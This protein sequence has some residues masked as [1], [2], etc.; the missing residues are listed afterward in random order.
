MTVPMHHLLAG[1]A[2]AGLLFLLPVRD[3]N[4]QDNRN[5]WD[6]GTA[7][8]VL[9]FIA[10]GA[11]GGILGWRLSKLASKAK[12][13]DNTTE[14]AL[15]Q[16]NSSVKV[17]DG[18][19][20]KLETNS[21]ESIQGLSHILESKMNP[22]SVMSTVS[23]S[24]ETVKQHI[25]EVK[26][27]IERAIEK[28]E[29]NQTGPCT[30][31]PDQTIEIH[32]NQSRSIIIDANAAID[33]RIF[34]LLEY[35]LLEEL[36]GQ[37]IIA[38]CMT[39][40]L[41]RLEP[42]LRANGFDNLWSFQGKDKNRIDY[43]NNY[44][45]KI[46]DARLLQLTSG[47]DDDKELFQG[48]SNA[49]KKL[50]LLTSDTNGILITADR[51]LVECCRNRNVRVLNLDEL[52]KI[53]NKPPEIKPP[54]LKKGD[55]VDVELEKSNKNP[56]DAINRSCGPIIVVKDAVEFIGQTKRVV[57][58]GALKNGRAYFASLLPSPNA[59]PPTV[60]AKAPQTP[61]AP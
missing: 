21:E 56:N 29:N 33:G 47:T 18:K 39:N 59:E 13:D 37:I 24:L 49:D 22:G 20:T 5:T 4:A 52:N 50:F 23:T 48:I 26:E 42:E 60:E 28:K 14:L 16:L 43:N 51:K 12:R 27:M 32:N 35:D 2:V 61:P 57:I 36:R 25:I 44:E 58:T 54:I 3:A 46:T 30:S 1:S 38:E 41:K 7:G 53:T 17:L 9:T 11:V 10:G 31:N 45:S 19:L 40:E 34:T 8:G 55:E 15:T 6:W